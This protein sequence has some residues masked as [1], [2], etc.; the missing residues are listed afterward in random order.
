MGAVALEYIQTNQQVSVILTKPLTKGK[1]RMFRE[2]L[3]LVKNTFLGK[4]EC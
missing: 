4:R 1:S 2:K 3:R